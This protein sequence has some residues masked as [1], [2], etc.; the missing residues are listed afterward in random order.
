M[1]DEEYPTEEQLKTIREW[2]IIKQGVTPLVQYVMDIWHWDDYCSL[3]GKKL[4]LHTG[5]WSGN[6]EIIDALLVNE[7][8]WMLCWRNTERGGHYKFQI[9]EVKR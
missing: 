6:E 3:E 9:K 7:M 8:F 5:G 2:D 4:E 1:S